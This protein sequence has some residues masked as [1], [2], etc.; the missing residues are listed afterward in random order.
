MTSL[1]GSTAFV[2]VVA[3]VAAGVGVVAAAVASEHQTV[4]LVCCF[5]CSCSLWD[6]L[7][8]GTG[9]VCWWGIGWWCWADGCRDGKLGGAGDS[10]A[11]GREM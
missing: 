3:V 8:V 11:G 6:V 5:R 9:C 10:D 4:L 2:R 7:R 1:S